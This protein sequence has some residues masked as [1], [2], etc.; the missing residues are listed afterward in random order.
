[1]ESAIIPKKPG[2]GR[3]GL[4]VFALKTIAILTMLIDHVGAGLYPSQ[5][6]FRV[7]G[8]IAFPIFAFLVC[9]GFFHTRN[10]R[11]YAV[12]LGIFAI[13]SEIPFNLLHSYHL[14]D[15][16]AQ[17]VFFTLLIGLLTIYGVSACAQ[18]NDNDPS[19]QYRRRQGADAD[20]ADIRGAN[21]NKR[22]I[23]PGA[24]KMNQLLVLLAGLVLAQLL[25]TDYGAFGVA[26]IFIFYIFHGRR[27]MAL[28]FMAAANLTLG[29]IDLVYGFMPL[30]ALAAAAAAPIMF[31]NGEKG[32]SLKYAFY[33][34][35]PAHIAVIMAVKYFVLQLPY[36]IS[37]Y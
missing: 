7:I 14:F 30:Q 17:N 33:I 26:I 25:R 5:I 11:R 37:N 24:L 9:E 12:R 4:N 20:A 29:A 36:Q 13:I 27:R 10:V 6:W 23:E 15:P 35:Y 18:K 8:R 32:P 31:Y 21:E 34:F 28:I 2:G 22:A 19:S 1:M 3:F 16:D